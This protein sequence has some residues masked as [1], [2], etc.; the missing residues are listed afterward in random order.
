M[1]ERKYLC[2]C[3]RDDDKPGKGN[4]WTQHADADGMFDDGSLLRRRK[5]FTQAKKNRSQRAA[6][7]LAKGK[8]V[9]GIFDCF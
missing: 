1:N 7:A 2:S 5:R 8:K 6:E 4:Y 9:G 3:I